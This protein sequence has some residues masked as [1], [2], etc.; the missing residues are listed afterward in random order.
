MS[1]T[2]FAPSVVSFAVVGMMSTASQSSPRPEIVSDTPSATDPE[3]E[4]ASLRDL[5]G[6]CAA[7]VNVPLHDVSAHRVARAKRALQVHLRAR[8]ELTEPSARLGLAKDIR[9]KARAIA[10]DDCK[11]HAVNRNG[12]PF[13][14]RFRPRRIR[15][16]FE[17]KPRT[18]RDALYRS[19]SLY[20][21]CE[22]NERLK[23]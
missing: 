10:L 19:D 8:H 9:S 2:F 3:L 13:L 11:A 16:D 12:L 14:E 22:H 21:A 1:P 15:R 18:A 5:R 17:D 6:D 20:K 7:A 23:S 4:V